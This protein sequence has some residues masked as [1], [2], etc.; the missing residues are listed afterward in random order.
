MSGIEFLA[1]V[2]S[3]PSIL[4]GVYEND[5]HLPRHF[6]HHPHDVQGDRAEGRSELWR[7]QR[8]VTG[9]GVWCGMCGC[10]D[11]GCWTRLPH[12]RVWGGVERGV[13]E[14][15][16]RRDEPGDEKERGSMSSQT[17]DSLT[18][19]LRG[20]DWREFSRRLVK[21][22]EQMCVLFSL[23]LSGKCLNEKSVNR[24]KHYT[25]SIWLTRYIVLHFTIYERLSV[26]EQIRLLICLNVMNK[27]IKWSLLYGRGGNIRQLT[28]IYWRLSHSDRRQKIGV[29]HLIASN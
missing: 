3:S 8:T 14:G 12:T 21:S 20:D 2:T 23:V 28:S 6:V 1:G 19:S 7:E 17:F 9:R 24:Q 5:P 10:G 4:D 25:S 11:R 15:I 13:W 27:S 26:W 29:N 22:T 18:F 16:V